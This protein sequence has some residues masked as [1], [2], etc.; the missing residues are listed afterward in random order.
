MPAGRGERTA[1]RANQANVALLAQ[2]LSCR[3]P[4]CRAGQ[5]LKV[6]AVPEIR[7]VENG[8]ETDFSRRLCDVRFEANADGKTADLVVSPKRDPGL[9]VELGPD[10]SGEL[11]TA[12]TW[13]ADLSLK[14]GFPTDPT[15]LVPTAP[16]AFTLADDDTGALHWIG[17]TGGVAHWFAGPDA[18]GGWQDVRI[19]ARRMGG[20][21][22][23]GFATV[24]ENGKAY[25]P[26]WTEQE[27]RNTQLRIR[28]DSGSYMARTLLRKNGIS[29][30]TPGSRK[31]E[32]LSRPR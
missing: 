13:T 9:M 30:S 17:W 21:S 3:I 22:Y 1:N 29:I 7:V 24:D 23:V 10:A 20:R 25:L 26:I 18:V 27:S 16:V 8:E 19:E 4:L 28:K 12:E 11:P 2:V 31:A 5:S 32:A 6:N 15:G 14:F